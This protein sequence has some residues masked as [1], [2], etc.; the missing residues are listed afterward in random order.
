MRVY[1][2]RKGLSISVSSADR[3]RLEAIVADRNTCQKHA[4]RARIILL[5]AAGVGTNGVI[6]A[7]GK[8]KTTVWRWQER[9][10]EAGVDGLLVDRTR[11]PGK[12]PVADE[13]VAELVRLTHEPPPHEATHWTARAMAKAVGL[14]VATVQKIWKAHGLAPHRWRAFKLSRD[15]AFAEKLHDIVGLYVSPPAH[16]VVLSVT[17]RARSRRSTGRS[18]ACR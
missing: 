16:A 18:R 7:T 1:G 4:W 8:S 12:A 5:T 10:A 2:M 14:G 11:P 9:F 3:R 17:R 6:A 15:P 13:R